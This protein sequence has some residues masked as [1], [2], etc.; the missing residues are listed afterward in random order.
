MKAFDCTKERKRGMTLNKIISIWLYLDV[1]L[2]N[3]AL[4][5][6]R[7]QTVMTQTPYL[8]VFHTLPHIYCHVVRSNEYMCLNRHFLRLDHPHVHQGITLSCLKIQ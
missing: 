7:S 4:L 3:M 1:D 5:Q 8:D 2:H 6:D